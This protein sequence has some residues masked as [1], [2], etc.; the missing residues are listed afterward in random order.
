MKKF[1]SIGALCAAIF[2]LVLTG[3]KDK[4]FTVTFDSQGGTPVE[5][6]KKVE[7][8]SKITEPTSPTKKDVEFCGWYRE[9]ACIN[10]W[11]FAKDVVTKNITLYAKWGKAEVATLEWV[12]YEGYCDPHSQEAEGFTL[13]FSAGGNYYYIFLL[14]PDAKYFPVDKWVPDIGTYQ[15]DEI[16]GAFIVQ[17]YSYVDTS[18]ANYDFVSGNVKITEVTSIYDPERKIVVN[19]VDETGVRHLFT[20]TGEFFWSAHGDEPTTTVNAVINATICSYAVNCGDWFGTGENLNFIV[21]DAAGNYAVFDFICTGSGLTS[22]PLGVYPIYASYDLNTV[23]SYCKEAIAMQSGSYIYYN[24]N[25]Y[26]LISGG[27]VVTAGGFQLIGNTYHDSKFTVN[28]T[29]S[30]AVPQGGW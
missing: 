12:E 9:A 24:G 17:G 10:G 11:N 29:G 3:C 5:S 7:N 23:V 26:G 19:L 27:V 25:R 20:Y 22:L 4:T 14:S 21:A 6:I 2:A 16:C 13:C 15:F 8:G 30:L 28:Y 18:T 1:F